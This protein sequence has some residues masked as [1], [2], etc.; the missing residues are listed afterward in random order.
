MLVLSRRVGE[1][2]VIAGGICITVV[3]VEGGRVRLGVT[4]P[5][6]VTVDRKEVA[7]RR[8]LQAQVAAPS[9][10]RLLLPAGSP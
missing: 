4:A 10:R 3:G 1:Q 5:P 8:A 9:R 7:E 2:V 6:S